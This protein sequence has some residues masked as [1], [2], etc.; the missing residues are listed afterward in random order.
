MA[1]DGLCNLELDG[2][3]DRIEV[4]EEL[5]PYRHGN[6]AEPHNDTVA[7]IGRL[8]DVLRVSDEVVS[9]RS[10]RGID[11]VDRR[12][13][14]TGEHRHCGV[15][16]DDGLVFSRRTTAPDIVKRGTQFRPPH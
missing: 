4:V 9:D 15:A 10:H 3:R 1:A 12:S 8:D 5:V 7:M 11:A 2:G 14:K 13:P 6:R 16:F